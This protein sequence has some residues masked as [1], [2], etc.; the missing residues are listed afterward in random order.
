MKS[1]SFHFQLLSTATKHPKMISLTKIIIY[2]YLITAWL[3]HTLHNKLHISRFQGRCDIANE[4]RPR[5]TN[6]NIVPLFI[7]NKQ[8]TNQL[9]QS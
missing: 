9:N 5:A 7:K 3:W 8:R 2:K 1:L 6:S 4:I